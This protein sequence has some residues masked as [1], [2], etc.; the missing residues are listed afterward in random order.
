[1]FKVRAAFLPKDI[2]YVLLSKKKKSGLDLNSG[3]A[4]DMNT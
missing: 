4:S 2:R 3:I 1:M